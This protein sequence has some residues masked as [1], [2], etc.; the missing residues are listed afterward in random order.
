MSGFIGELASYGFV[1][2]LWLAAFNLIPVPP[3]DGSKV[4]AWSKLIW[5][6]IAIPTWLFV[7]LF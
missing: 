7:L 3:L 4:F 5:A 6:I 1:V 2:N